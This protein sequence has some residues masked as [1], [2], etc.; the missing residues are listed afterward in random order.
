MQRIIYFGMA[1]L[2]VVTTS[3]A[4][5]FCSLTVLV[6]SPKG[7]PIGGVPVEAIESQTGRALRTRSDDRGESLLCDLSVLPVR[8]V[9]GTP[10]CLQVEA[11]S[12]PIFWGKNYAS[13]PYD[14]GANM[15]QVDLPKDANCRIAMRVLDQGGKAVP[16]ALITFDSI[17]PQQGTPT[18][19]RRVD[20]YGRVL[21]IP[22]FGVTVNGWAEA[23]GFQKTAFRVECRFE[24]RVFQHVIQL[25]ARVEAEK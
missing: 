8:I 17:P 3:H 23:P 12:F 20:E 18:Q 7:S 16:A 10:N 2:C 1:L 24:E 21:L 19:R 14:T 25:P 11:S 9:V 6:R 15:C 5:T 22:Q 13:V 4:E